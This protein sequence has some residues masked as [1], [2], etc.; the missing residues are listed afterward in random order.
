MSGPEPSVSGQGAGAPS[1]GAPAAWFRRT[2]TGLNALGSGWIFVLM[3]IID[4]DAIG[5]TFFDHPLEG[6]IEITQMSIV[7]IVFLSFANDVPRVGGIDTR[8][9]A[10]NSKFR[11]VLA[12]VLIATLI[13]IIIHFLF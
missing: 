4:A 2:V 1:E 10:P 7:A 13:G 5:R 12:V 8:K 11:W 3:L 9:G 6:V